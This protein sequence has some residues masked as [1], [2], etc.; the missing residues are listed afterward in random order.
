DQPVCLTDLYATCARVVGATLTPGEA[1]DSFAINQLLAGEN[2][3]RPEPVVHHSVAGMFAIRDGEWKLIAGNG[4][5]G[6]DLP[7][8]KPFGKPYQLFNL[9]QDRA[10]NT[11]VAEHHPEVVQRLTA[12]LTELIELDR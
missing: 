7:K 10:E 3:A 11:D 5:G 1:P 8:G 6:R 9:A 12:R 2:V 4:S